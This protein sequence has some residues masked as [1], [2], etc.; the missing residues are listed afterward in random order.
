MKDDLIEKL[1]E[2]YTAWLAKHGFES[3][4]ADELLLEETLTEEQR[5]WVEDFC[6]RWDAATRRHEV[7]R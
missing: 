2:Q 1:V 4:S 6:V 5:A 3:C 7:A